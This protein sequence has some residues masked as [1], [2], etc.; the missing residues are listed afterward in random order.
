MDPIITS[1][2]TEIIKPSSSAPDRKRI[3]KLSLLDQLGSGAYV[4]NILFYRRKHLLI[5]SKNHLLIHFYPLA[6]KIKDNLFVD[7]DDLG[8]TFVETRLARCCDM[9]QVIKEP[10]FHIRLTQLITT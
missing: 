9:S 2:S 3:Y 8:V 10:I 5:I 7:C 4:S 6:G 1:S